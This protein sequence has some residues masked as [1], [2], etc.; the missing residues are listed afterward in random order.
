MSTSRLIASTCSSTPSSCQHDVE[1]ASPP[2]P[3]QQQQHKQPQHTINTQQS[4][5]RVKSDRQVKK[6]HR[7]ISR[8]KITIDTEKVFDHF[9][10]SVQH[11][12][13]LRV[14][15]GRCCLSSRDAIE[16]EELYVEFTGARCANNYDDDDSSDVYQNF[17][18]LCQFA[19]RQEQSHQQKDEIDS[20]EKTNRLKHHDYY[21]ID[22]HSSQDG[23]CMEKRHSSNDF[24]NFSIYESDSL[25]QVSSNLKFPSKSGIQCKKANNEY[26]SRLEM[27]KLSPPSPPLALAEDVS[28]VS[29]S[30]TEDYEFPD[31]EL[32]NRKKKSSLRLAFERVQQS[33][34]RSVNKKSIPPTNAAANIQP[35]TGQLNDKELNSSSQKLKDQNKKLTRQADLGKRS[36]SSSKSELRKLN[37]TEPPEPS[38]LTDK[39]KFNKNFFDAILKQIRVGRSKSQKKQ[40]NRFRSADNLPTII[41]PLKNEDNELLK[42]YFLPTTFHDVKKKGSSRGPS[43]SLERTCKRRPA[44]PLPFDEVDGLRTLDTVESRNSNKPVEEKSISSSSSNNVPFHHKSEKEKDEIFMKIADQLAAIA[45]NI[46]CIGELNQI[47]EA[48]RT[49]NTYD[50]SHVSV[51]SKA[52]AN[53]ANEVTE[54]LLNNTSSYNEFEQIVS[55]N[56]N[57]NNCGWNQIAHVFMLTRSVINLAGIGS[58]VAGS[59]KGYTMKYIEE[60]YSGWIADRGGWESVVEDGDEQSPEITSELD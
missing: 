7:N 48:P 37:V 8:K 53:S 38:K 24:N 50:P 10:H 28:D 27:K 15:G 5:Q 4:D 29:S 49:L 13:L 39:I 26:I 56:L 52:C 11:P 59:I 34:K 19:G 31:T 55:A 35:N 43:V 16:D 22:Y 41:R 32:I 47:V 45:D 33:F 3:Q 18:P 46:Q 58:T 30:S 17:K 20:V 25:L 44:M 21:D 51:S 1:R 54:K 40:K 23:K 6:S 60:K 42:K 14:K 36:R 12:S 2:P 9:L 57:E